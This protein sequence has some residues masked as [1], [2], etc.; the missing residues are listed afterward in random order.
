MARLQCGWLDYVRRPEDR[1]MKKMKV[2]QLV[3]VLAMLL[4]A[5]IAGAQKAVAGLPVAAA[6]ASAPVPDKIYSAKRVFISNAGSDSQLFGAYGFTGDPDR[7]Y[8][9]FYGDVKSSG[10]YQLVS[11]PAQ[12]DMV[13]EVRL[14]S[15]P[16]KQLPMLRLAIYDTA[17]HYTLWVLTESI[18]EAVSQKNRDKNF[19]Q[20][21]VNLT[22]DLKRVA[23]PFTTVQ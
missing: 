11:D 13:L 19:S 20:A 6:Q 1:K 5:G 15:M 17:T 7:T 16:D 23:T 9:E 3:A 4:T 18:E 12:S 22:E 14:Y 2:A 8:T 21:L 10:R